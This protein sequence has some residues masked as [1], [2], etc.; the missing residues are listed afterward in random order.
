MKGLLLLPCLLSTE[1]SEQGYAL[2]LAHKLPHDGPK[3]ARR[4][5]PQE[6]PPIE[7]E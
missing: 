6:Q 4:V 3:G 7:G 5:E 1:L 2:S